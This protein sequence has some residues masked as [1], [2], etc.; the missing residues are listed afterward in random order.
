[1]NKY[2]NPEPDNQPRRGEIAREEAFRDLPRAQIGAINCLIDIIDEPYT[3]DDDADFKLRRNK[4][5]AATVLMK[6][7]F[8][9]GRIQ[10]V[11]LRQGN[12]AGRLPPRQGLAKDGK[13]QRGYE[14][15]LRSSNRQGGARMAST[16]RPHRIIIPPPAGWRDDRVRESSDHRGKQQALAD[17]PGEIGGEDR[18]SGLHCIT[19]HVSPLSLW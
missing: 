6:T 3:G 9:R 15:F 11:R 19:R 17:R 16:E 7:R 8:L 10:G 12:R 4:I 1:M 13:V 14:T 2:V 18:R 5:A